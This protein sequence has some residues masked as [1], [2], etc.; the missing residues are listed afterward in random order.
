MQRMQYNI[1]AAARGGAAVSSEA[2]R[3]LRNVYFTLALT[4]IPT[5][6]GAV[7]GTALI[8]AIPGLMWVF[9]FA[10]LLV[11]IPAQIYI[12]RNAWSPSALYALFGFTF[13]MGMFLGNILAVALTFA[14]GA[15]II[16]LSAGMTG[17]IFFSMSAMAT[18]TR[19]DLGGLGKGL[20]IGMWM[21]LAVSLISIFFPSAA[22]YAAISA[23]G[24]AIFSL[25]IFYDIN[26]VVRGGETNYIVATTHVYISIWAVFQY[27]LNLLL[28]FAGNRE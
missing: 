6:V 23:V 25:F 8:R 2:R 21:L 17:A 16:A 20:M 15:T 22:L 7:V 3:V 5:A 13:L 27:L 12:H 4:M 1:P 26:R 11:M 10:P 18:V 24:A 28:M 14:N 9:A 19:R